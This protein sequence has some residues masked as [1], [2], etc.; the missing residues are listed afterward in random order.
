MTTF[1]KALAASAVALALAVV[2]AQTRSS[3]LE[4]FSAQ[5]SPPPTGL[6]GG[7]TTDSGCAVD[8]HGDC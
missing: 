7:P 5:I 4:V 1:R 8:P 3:V 6:G 2:P